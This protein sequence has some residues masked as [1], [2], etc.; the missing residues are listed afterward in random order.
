MNGS[1]NLLGL[2]LLLVASAAVADPSAKPDACQ[3]RISKAWVRA[4]PPGTMMMAG[5][6]TVTN[7]CATPALIVGADSSDF[8]DVSVHE[9]VVEGGIS[10]MRALPALPVPAGARVEFAPGGAHLMLMAPARPMPEGSQA[11][12]RLRLQDGS[13]LV[14]VYQVRR[15]APAR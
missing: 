11:H 1:Q 14:A 4:A 7:P 15:E 3:L 8:G 6:A 5:Y 13:E 2:A 10:R 12:I 9:T